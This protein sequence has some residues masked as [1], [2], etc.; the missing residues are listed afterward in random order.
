VKQRGCSLCIQTGG[1]SP[2]RS[3]PDGWIVFSF[4]ESLIALKLQMAAQRL[5][6]I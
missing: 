4:L 6:C 2:L 1:E 5:S 3:S